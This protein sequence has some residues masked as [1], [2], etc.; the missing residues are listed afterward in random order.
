[1]SD[2]IYKNDKSAILDLC[3]RNAIRYARGEIKYT[4]QLEDQLKF[5]YENC[6]ENTRQIMKTIFDIVEFE[7]K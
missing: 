3:L 2:I 4:L 7:E 6:G 5:A 1:M